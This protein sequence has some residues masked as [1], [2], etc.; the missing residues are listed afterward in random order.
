MS[1]G[2]DIQSIEA[3]LHALKMLGVNGAE[4]GDTQKSS[5][6]WWGLF[7][8]TRAKIKYPLYYK[9][10]HWSY[11]WMEFVNYTPE[12]KVAFATK[13][14]DAKVKYPT[15]FDYYVGTRFWLDF[16]EWDTDRQT[17]YAEADGRARAEYGFLSERW[18]GKQET[19]T[20]FVNK[21]PE[22]QQRRAREVQE[23]IDRQIR[24]KK[25]D[26]FWDY[27]S[28]GDTYDGYENRVETHYD[29]NGKITK[30][31]HHGSN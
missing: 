27:G 10:Y 22:A 30:E 11:W 25:M 24:K 21:T 12:M 29:K 6:D 18:A 31:I 2:A 15:I 20:D 5:F 26:H 13:F 3:N 8:E 4:N 19:W 14:E 23:I 17:A 28:Y 1:Q 16:L 7:K 9:K